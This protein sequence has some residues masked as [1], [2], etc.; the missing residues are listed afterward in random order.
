MSSRSPLR[1]ALLFAGCLLVLSGAAKLAVR[2]GVLDGAELSRRAGMITA[3]LVLAFIGNSLP[4]TLTPL[5]A[6]RCDPARAQ[7]LERWSGW[8]WMLT[9]LGYAVVWMVAPFDLAP[10]VSI[11]LV[12]A[13]MLL[14]VARMISL[15][16][17]RPR[18]T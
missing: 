1:S 10:T 13:A 7:T 6:Q 5:S 3:G 14:V 9:G 11:A 2:L 8:T 12:A 17:A 15:R 18:S 4:K 16:R